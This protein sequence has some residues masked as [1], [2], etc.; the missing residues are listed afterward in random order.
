MRHVKISA[1]ALLVAAGFATL[2]SGQGIMIGGQ[3]V[4]EAQRPAIEQK[5]AELA[6]KVVGTTT[7]D[8]TETPPLETPVADDGAPNDVTPEFDLA[9]VTLESC[10]EAGF[11]TTTASARSINGMAVPSDQMGA[12]EERCLELG[13]AS[14]T[15]TAATPAPV[16]TEDPTETPPLETPVAEQGGTPNDV[17]P[18]IDLDLITADACGVGG[19]PTS[20]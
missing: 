1:A 6:G 11:S 2:A 7:E 8:P 4:P 20:Q 13:L 5:C 3:L 12:V 10:A 18:T 9:S 19:F 15:A 16:T 14:A 17:T